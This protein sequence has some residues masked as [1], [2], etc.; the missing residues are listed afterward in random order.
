VLV[1]LATP[2]YFST[3]RIPL[4]DG[5]VFGAGDL[6]GEVH[7]VIVNRAFA[8]RYFAGA[9]GLGRRVGLRGDALTVVGVVE[10][11]RHEAVTEPATPTWYL[12]VLP[13][14]QPDWMPMY[15]HH[16][17]VAIRTALPPV[18]LAASVR[19]IVRD[20]DS[21]L[22]VS[23]IRTMEDIVA[24]STVRTTFTMLLMLVAALAALFL[25]AVGVYGVMAYAV[26]RR[27]HEMGV[28]IALG[29]RASELVALVLRQAAWVSAVGLAVGMLGALA[30]TRLL[31]GL[32]FEVTPTDPLSFGGTALVLL[33]ATL[34]ASWIPARRATRVDPMEAL[35]Y[36]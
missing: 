28:R 15:P 20:L 13:G 30:L 34:L 12:P 21:N 17:G 2:D 6:Q 14:A 35:R 1:I 5:R 26:G 23:N 31:R 33:A 8:R 18:S 32:L 9:S 27:T 22:P 36:E 16:M 11:V 29:A 7:P 25:G 24:T 19:Q 4:V 10:D 3:M